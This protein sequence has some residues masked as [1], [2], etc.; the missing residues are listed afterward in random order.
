MLAFFNSFSYN[1]LNGNS[2]NILP[3]RE[4]DHGLRVRQVRNIP[5]C[6]L[7]GFFLLREW[8]AA[9]SLVIGSASDKFGVEPRV[10]YA[11]VGSNRGFSYFLEVYRYV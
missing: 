11:S 9:G 3:R 5:K 8:K 7:R 4:P 6:A 10:F 1:K 2:K